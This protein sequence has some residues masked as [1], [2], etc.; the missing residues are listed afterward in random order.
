MNLRAA[1]AAVHTPGA[2][3]Q[4]QG[5]PP[6]WEAYPP[7][8]E[9]TREKTEHGKENPAQP[10]VSQWKQATQNQQKQTS[11]TL[12]MA[13]CLLSQKEKPELEE[14]AHRSHICPLLSCHKGTKSYL[15][16]ACLPIGDRQALAAEGPRVEHFLKIFTYLLIYL[17]VPGLS[18][19]IGYIFSCGTWAI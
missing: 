9:E 19:M 12:P 16:K 14:K 5:K 11:Y 7:P 13:H 2:C 15:F 8:P 1:A 4:R 10:K 17:A 3:A 6:P 18:C